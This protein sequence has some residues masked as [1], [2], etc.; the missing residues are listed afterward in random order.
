MS[1]IRSHS[2]LCITFFSSP[3]FKISLKR[4]STVK[5]DISIGEKINEIRSVQTMLE[6]FKVFT[7]PVKVQKLSTNKIVE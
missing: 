1:D 7:I 5:K 3:C 2:E 6:N 4:Y